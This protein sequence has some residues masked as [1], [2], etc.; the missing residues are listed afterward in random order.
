MTDFVYNLGKS[1][2][3][4]F[5]FL[6]GYI[7][8]SLIIISQFLFFRLFNPAVFLVTLR[9]IYF[10]GVQIIRVV[11][12]VSFFLGLGLVGFLGKFLFNIGAADHIGKILILTIVREFAPLVTAILLSF[13]TSTAISAEIS[14]MKFGNEINTLRSLGIN[15]YNYLYIP[16]VFAGIVCSFSLAVF[17]TIVSVMVGYF[18]LSFKLHMTFDYMIMMIFNE[19]DINDIICFIY[20]TVLFGF[21]LITI[22][23]YTSATSVGKYSTD[24]PIALSKGMMRLFY[25]LIIVEITGAMI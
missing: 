16:R 23:I 20:K 25:G 22:P 10:T 13:R 1:F 9:Q 6:K 8:F 14:M 2:L 15:E 12:I 11:I 7:Y 17:F 3:D 19:L 18:L 4:F 5:R 24:V 21:V